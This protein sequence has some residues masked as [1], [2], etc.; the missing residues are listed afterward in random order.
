M[1]VR[2][3]DMYVNEYRIPYLA[4]V[5]DTIVTDDEQY[6]SPQKIA[7]IIRL[8]YKVD[9]LPE[10]H[11]WM[12]AFDTRMHMIG[13][14]ELSRGSSNQSTVSINQ[15]LQRALLCGATCTVLV[16]NHPS[17]DPS[18]SREDISFTETVKNAMNICGIE[19]SDHIII[20]GANKKKYYSFNES[21]VG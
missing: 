4:A 8:L 13:I 12:L 3:Y 18:P 1:N 15:I 9:I 10:E 6:N 16:H 11:I 7:D 20:G 21:E 5:G 17:G 14:F 2:E 19:F